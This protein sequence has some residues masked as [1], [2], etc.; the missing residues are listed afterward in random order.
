MNKVTEG[1]ISALRAL[2]EKDKKEAITILWDDDEFRLPIL[3]FI[4]ERLN[5][6]HIEK[7]EI[8]VEAK[9]LNR[10]EIGKQERKK[11]VNE[12]RGK[13]ITIEL[14]QR[15]WGK[16]LTGLLVAIPF[17]NERRADRWFLGIGEIDLLNK[18]AQNKVSIILLC[19]SKAGEIAD[20]VIPP[21]KVAEII[22]YLTVSKGHYVF[23]LRRDGLEYQLLLPEEKPMD[24]TDYR[25]KIFV[26]K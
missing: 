6:P 26:L 7:E 18:K 9:K 10:R 25:G 13:G 5:V 11:Y 1:L 12:L 14:F 17:A 2:P 24:L 23:N 8:E 3:N 15:I 4:I 22:P 20:F 19:K 21:S 16:T